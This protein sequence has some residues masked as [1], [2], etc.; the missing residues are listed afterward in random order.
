M[1]TN[2]ETEVRNRVREAI[3]FYK[4]AGKEAT[5]KE[6][7]KADGRFAVNDAYLFALDL[8]GKMLAHPINEELTGR[9]LI[10][11]RDSFGKSFI[12]RIVDIA[13]TRGYGFTEYEWPLP[14]SSND[15]R[16]TTFFEKVDDVVLCCGFH[17][18]EVSSYESV[19]DRLFGP[20]E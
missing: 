9:N 13:K 7:G 18:S 14:G 16:K 2:G 10:E 12:R 8:D 20:L 1:N 4:S 3:A 11:L 17:G 5:L 19:F 6:I 15:C